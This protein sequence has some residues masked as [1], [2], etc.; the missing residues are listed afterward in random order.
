MKKIFAIAAIA[1][2]ALSVYAGGNRQYVNAL[3]LNIVNRAQPIDSGFD[4]LGTDR[5]PDLS[6]RV[7]KYCKHTTG[8]AVAFRTNSREIDAK[9]KTQLAAGG[10]NIN[11][12]QWGGLALYIK[13]DG[14]WQ[15]AGAGRPTMKTKHHDNMVGNLDGTTHDCLLYLPMWTG[16][17]SL[18]IGVDSAAV[19]TP[20][21][22]PF[23]KRVVVM[24]SSITHG[25]SASRPGIDFV[26][27]LQ[28]LTDWE[29]PNL[30]YSGSC[31][32]EPALAQV[33]ADTKADA[34]VFDP[35]SNPSPEEITSRFKPF[36]DTIR[37]AH[38][39]T[40]L[41]FIQT[42][43]RETGNFNPGQRDFEARKRQAARDAFQSLVNA[44]YKDIY[45]IDPGMPL[46]PGHDDTAD[47]IHPTDAGF[48]KI[49][50][51]LLPRL[52]EILAPYGIM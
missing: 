39:T 1:L 11:P 32:M 5:Y 22:N 30:G 52:R 47:G 10:F 33:I 15:Y 45:L 3:D 41:I 36:V 38:P 8:L 14:K 17:D 31:K 40:P 12:M 42:L 50:N 9:W 26:A 13:R 19:V 7:K 51:H 6:D 2:G 27:R 29:M 4:R 34:F 21:P 46:D 44:G 25:A 48:E 35:F 16:V 24:G 18:T 28:R 43:V 23:T 37:A 49:T 20:L